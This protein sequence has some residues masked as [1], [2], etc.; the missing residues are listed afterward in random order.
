MKASDPTPSLDKARQVYSTLPRVPVAYHIW[1]QLMA[2][3][4]REG[5]VQAALPILG[6]DPGLAAKLLT[7]ANSVAF[8]GL[9][10]V[11]DLEQAVMRLGTM[12]TLRVVAALVFRDVTQDGL[13]FYALTQDDFLALSMETGRL[14]ARHAERA[15]LRPAEGQSLG[16]LR[17]LGHWFLQQAFRDTKAEPPAPFA[18]PY[19]EAARWEEEQFGVNHAEYGAHVLAQNKLPPVLVEPL[20]LYL[21]PADGPWL[22]AA[23]LLRLVTA[24]AARRVIPARTPALPDEAAALALLRMTADELEPP[25]P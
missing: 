24:R 1:T 20:R 5:D 22:K 4:V 13:P 21:A 19:L 12:E 25:A 23:T 14:M 7:Y 17:G 16:L 10:E 6:Q 8:A 15:G 11:S 2:S 18:G 3:T 9:S